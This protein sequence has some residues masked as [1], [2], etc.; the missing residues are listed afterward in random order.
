MKATV[1]N[2][3][4]LIAQNAKLKITAPEGTVHTSV[5]EGT[6]GYADS[7]E[8]RKNNYTWRY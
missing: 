3:G 8:K 4:D 5:P 2:N 7:N 6:K 1:K